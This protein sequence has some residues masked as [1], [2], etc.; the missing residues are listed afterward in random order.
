ME[1]PAPLMCVGGAPK[2]PA[3]P[4]P[5][6]AVSAVAVEEAAP[7]SGGDAA[8]A[9][10]PDAAASAGGSGGPA[11]VSATP[12]AGLRKRCAPSRH[13]GDSSLSPKEPS[14]SDTRMSASSGASH[15]RMSQLTMVTRA[16]HVVAFRFRSVTTAFGF[17]ST[18][19]TR[20]DRCAASAARSARV[21]SGP[22][23]AP[24]TIT[25][26]V[27]SAGVSESAS[28]IAASYC[29]YLTGSRSK[30]SYVCDSRLSASGCSGACGG[31]EGR[32]VVEGAEG[33]LNRLEE[34]GEYHWM[35][36]CSA[37]L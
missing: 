2:A 8:P 5:A 16:P 4:A 13:S 21:T 15:R 29:W 27:R 33:V 19:Y 32:R 22:R 23:P 26:L 28:W 1:T 35:I 3:A 37:R 25:T 12:P 11:G 14:S 20:T 7:G 10:A 17:F 30:V 6:A 24:T 18:A 36:G 9:P 34:V 31:G